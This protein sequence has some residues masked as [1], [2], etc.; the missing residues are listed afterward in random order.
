[1]RA[2]EGIMVCG[3]TYAEHSLIGQPKAMHGVVGIRTFDFHPKDESE[4]S[5]RLFV[6]A[7][8]AFS[9]CL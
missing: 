7:K 3:R 6:G 8:I 2:A 4:A 9:K 1:M 5:V